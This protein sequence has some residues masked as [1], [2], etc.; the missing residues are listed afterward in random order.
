MTRRLSHSYSSL[1][2]FDNCPK[3]YYHQRVTKEVVDQ[4]GEASKHGERVHKSLEERLGP[5]RVPLPPELSKH[6]RLCQSIENV[7]PGAVIEPERELVIKADLTTTHWKDPEAWLR[8]K[9]DVMALNGRRGLCID[10]KTGTRRP[11]FF[12]LEIS[13]LQMF[14]HFPELDIITTAFVWLREDKMDTEVYTREQYDEL[15]QLVRSK[16]QRVE[17]ALD[18]DVWPAKPSGLCNYCPAKSICSYAQ[19][20]GRRRRY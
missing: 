19:E 1:K 4:G 3:R 16:T 5:L 2:M 12:Q 7:A 15:L 13:A 20:S 18:H 11:D 10:F 14:V 17:Q 6:E 8:S 9:L